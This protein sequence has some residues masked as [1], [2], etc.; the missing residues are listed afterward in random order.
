VLSNYCSG[1]IKKNLIDGASGIYGR[2]ES[3]IW[4]FGGPNLREKDHLEDLSIDVNIILIWIMK[5]LG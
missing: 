2:K 3:Y 1:V 4:G 5:E